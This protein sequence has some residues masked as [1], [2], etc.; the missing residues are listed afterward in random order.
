MIMSRIGI[1]LLWVICISCFSGCAIYNTVKAQ[2]ELVDGAKAY[3]DKKF[4]EAE[5]LFRHAIDRDPGKIMAQVFLARTLHSEFASN[6]TL[7]P[8]AEAAIVEYKK[9]VPIFTDELAKKKQALDAQPTNERAIR[10]YNQTLSILASS[11]SSTANLLDTTGKDVEWKKWQTDV[12]Q[13]ANLPNQVRVSAFTA[14]AAKENSC[15]NEITDIEP[16]KKTVKQ[17]GKDSY[18]FVKPPDQATYSK[19]KECLQRGSDF[20]DESIKLETD[21]VKNSDTIVV[22]SLSPARL[23]GLADSLR[24]FESAWSYRASLYVQAMRLAEMDGR[25]ADKESL[26]AK[27]DA[28]RERFNKLS[29]LEKKIQEEK[30]NRAAAAEAEKR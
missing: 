20:I 3:Q 1:L 18:V 28:A 29:E 17:D 21:T 6:R 14:L 9:V 30:D 19:L 11:I 16:Q 22:T 7:T 25:T 10:E 23:D 5:D 15:A 13:N 4:E 27:A 24:T 26:K 8:K 12:S 2:Q